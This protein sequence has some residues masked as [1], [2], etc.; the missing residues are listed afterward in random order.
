MTTPLLL[1]GFAAL[2]GG[3]AGQ[4]LSK[5][6]WPRHA[7]RLAVALWQALCFGVLSSVVLGAAALASPVLTGGVAGGFDDF[8]ARCQLVLRGETDASHPLAL[9]MSG[10]IVALATLGRVAWSAATSTRDARRTRRAQ[11]ERLL[12]VGRRL[13]GDQGE[14]LVLL[15]DDRSAAYCL[16]SRGRG[17]IV[18]STGSL[19]LLADDQLRLVLA[20]ERAHLRQRHHVAAQLSAVLCNAFGWVPLF[21][22]ASSEVP[23]LLEMAADDQAVRATATDPDRET[24]LRRSS[25][26]RLGHALVTLATAQPASPAGALAAAGSSA[27]ARV[28]RLSEPPLRLG[29]THIT[30]LGLGALTAFTGPILVTSA[31]AICA[32][33]MDICPFVSS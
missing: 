32:A 6:R 7:P 15:D 12:L 8:L 11:L 9:G 23:V 5:A 21:R 28:H 25:R 4:P 13:R 31:P 2:L 19:D 3:L 10:L 33:A 29:A 1:L 16:P 18:I 27:V 20:H 22:Y 14:D 24:D 30:L 17:T 26:R